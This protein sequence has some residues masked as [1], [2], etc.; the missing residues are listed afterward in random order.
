M[1]RLSETRASLSRSVRE[2]RLELYGE[3]GAPALAARLE[4]PPGTWRNFEAGVTMPAEV[5]LRFIEVT[6]ADPHWLLTGQGERYISRLAASGPG[7]LEGRP[8]RAAGP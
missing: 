8:D 5:L 3:A 6:G 4:L 2:I 1:P 7:S